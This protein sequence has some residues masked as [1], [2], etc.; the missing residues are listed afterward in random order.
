MDSTVH[1]VVDRPAVPKAHFVFGRV[2][3]DVDAA[4]IELE[5]ERVGRLAPLIE[6]FAVGLAHGVGDHLVPYPAPVDVEELQVRL[7]SRH[8]GQ[9]DP[10]PQ[11]HA[12]GLLVDGQAL[13]EEGVAAHGRDPLRPGVVATARRIAPTDAGVVPKLDRCL[14]AP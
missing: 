13:R 1:Q 4:G 10:A 8:G 7:A 14:E 2:N 9:T 6:H 12:T 3:V 5:V 11:A